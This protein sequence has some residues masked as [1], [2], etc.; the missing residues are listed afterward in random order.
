MEVAY[1]PAAQDLFPTPVDRAAIRRVP[2][3]KTQGAACKDI[4]GPT[5]AAVLER[6]F[7]G[8]TGCAAIFAMDTE[9]LYCS[10]VYDLVGK[11]LGGV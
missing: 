4:F 6:K 11:V 10:I 5:F 7:P 8:K 1:K 2:P 9:Y 3:S